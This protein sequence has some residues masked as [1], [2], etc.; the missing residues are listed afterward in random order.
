MKRKSSRWYDKGSLPIRTSEPKKRTYDKI[1]WSKPL[2]VGG[3][4]REGR[5][6]GRFRKIGV[7]DVFGKRV[8]FL[9]EGDVG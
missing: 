3:T 7:K 6:L 4:L 1:L 8:E 5:S 2:K 9:G